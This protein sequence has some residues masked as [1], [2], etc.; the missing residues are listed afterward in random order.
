MENMAYSET[1]HNVNV[2]NLNRLNEQIETFGAIYDPAKTSIKLV[3]LRQ[4]YLD[5]GIQ[6][7]NVQ[8]AKN[9]YSI[10]VDEREVVFKPLKP[11]TTRIINI[12]SG[13]DVSK[14]L[15]KDAKSINKKI[16]GVRI[17]NP[18]IQPQTQNTETENPEEE[19]QNNID[20]DP[21]GTRHSVSRQSHVTLQENFAD[22]VDLLKGAEGYNPNEPEFQI[23]AL[24]AYR[25]TLKTENQKID[26]AIAAVTIE[27]TNR[28]TFLYKPEQGLV[29]TALD[30]KNYIKGIFGATSPQFIAADKIHFRNR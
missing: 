9:A 2:A 23:A 28:N 25:E 10:K 29:D 19:P 14:Q 15:I 26:Q 18:N 22:L 16:Q 11:F 4:L 27:R 5:G 13:T 1:G 20:N 8:T 21:T 3:N 12:L 7:A 17:D 24:E 6:I 30:A